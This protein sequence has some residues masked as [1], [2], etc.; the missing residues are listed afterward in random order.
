MVD[1]GSPTHHL[2]LADS[3]RS[4]H[5]DLSSR[6]LRAVPTAEIAERASRTSSL[7]LSRNALGAPLTLP[8]MAQL[9]R[10]SL[11]DNALDAATLQRA[12]PLPE[13]LRVLDLGANRLTVLPPVVLR[14]SRLSVL[15]VDRQQ[16]RSLPA[17]LSL[18][19]AL[20]ELDAGFNELTDALALAPPGL[21]RLRR[22]V[23]RSNALCRGR[24]DLCA[25][26]LPSLTELDVA[27]NGLREWP[28]C[29]GTLCTLR[30]LHLSNNR[31]TS[32]VSARPMPHKRMWTPAGGVHELPRGICM[33]D[34]GDRPFPV[35]Q[36]GVCGRRGPLCV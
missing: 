26:R 10:L 34:G 8:P 32:L 28:E 17:Q 9:V 1:L 29:V 22:L 4:S 15:H 21:P 11:A 6:G 30:T 23:L 25:A 31:L 19:G 33:R 24:L 36:G 12:A 20:E 3:S 35:P 13:Y 14:L 7:D 27:G 2:S 18:L 16:L 5:L